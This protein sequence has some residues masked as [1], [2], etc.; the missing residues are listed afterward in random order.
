[1]GLCPVSGAVRSASLVANNWVVNSLAVTVL[2]RSLSNFVRMFVSIIY[3]SCS[4]IGYLESKTRS[5]KLKIEKS[6]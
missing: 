3:R 1:M 4:K 5:K 2:I 6:F